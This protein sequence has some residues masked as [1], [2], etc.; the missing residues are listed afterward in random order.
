MIV[1]ADR[2]REK[3]DRRYPYGSVY[4]EI[5][6]RQ[7]F[8]CDACRKSWERIFQIDHIVPLAYA[9]DM[10]AR[11]WTDAMR[12]RFANDPANLIAVA[13]QVNQDKGDQPPGAWMP[14][15]DAFWC[16]YAVQFIEVLRGYRLAVDEASAQRLRAATQTCPAG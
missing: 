16:Q 6:A 12:S 4:S 7:S 14:P 9:W 3:T 2:I 5:R 10:G 11:D 13:G 15:N 1:C 8:R